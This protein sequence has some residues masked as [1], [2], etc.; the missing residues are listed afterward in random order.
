MISNSP[1]DPTNIMAQHYVFQKKQ[2]QQEPDNYYAQEPYGNQENVSSAYRR[3]VQ[4]SVE[5][6]IRNMG[7]IFR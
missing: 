7:M 2:E 4:E 1:I 5:A 3:V 6:V